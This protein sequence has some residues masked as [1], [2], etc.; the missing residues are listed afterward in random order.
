MYIIGVLK[1]GRKVGEG[2]R[3]VFRGGGGLFLYILLFRAGGWT[4]AGTEGERVHVLGWGGVGL[5]NG[6][7]HNVK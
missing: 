2:G 4:E 7:D 3:K 1:S 5:G 6:G